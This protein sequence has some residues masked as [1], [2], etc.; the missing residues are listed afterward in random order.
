MSLTESIQQTQEILSRQQF[1][2]TEVLPT[3]AERDARREALYYGMVLGNNYKR[4][5]R[6]AFLT[7]EGRVDIESQIWAITE[8][9]ISLKG[10]A[11][12]PI[13]CIKSVTTL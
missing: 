13:G 11:T 5:V 3:Q 8:S 12:I 1:L 2:D 6:I 7:Y 4:K 10:G 9:K